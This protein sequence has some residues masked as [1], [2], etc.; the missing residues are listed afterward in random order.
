MKPIYSITLIRIG[1]VKIGFQGLILGD[2]KLV[3]CAP[4]GVEATRPNYSASQ[5][6]VENSDQ[7]GQ[8]TS[9]EKEKIVA[10]T[11]ME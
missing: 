5:H 7:L 2:Y 9:V 4:R 1:V 6:S 11:M 8:I 3:G 10:L